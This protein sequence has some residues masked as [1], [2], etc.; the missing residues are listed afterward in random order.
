[1][2]DEIPY[3]AGVRGELLVQVKRL[4]SDDALRIVK[5]L[6][7]EADALQLTPALAGLIKGYVD[8]PLTSTRVSKRRSSACCRMDTEAPTITG[9]G[10]AAL[11]GGSH[12][13]AGAG[14]AVHM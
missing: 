8:R 6:V 1:M 3:R 4:H 11:G 7:A 12:A 2:S 9:R 10:F 13:P 5:A 14:G